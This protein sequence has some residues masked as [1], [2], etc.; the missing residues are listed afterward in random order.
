MIHA[1][2]NTSVDFYLL[3]IYVIGIYL[4]TSLLQI[5]F[6]PLLFRNKNYH[7]LAFSSEYIGQDTDR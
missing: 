5:N 4:F 1:T 3:G 2:F 7:L 6:Y